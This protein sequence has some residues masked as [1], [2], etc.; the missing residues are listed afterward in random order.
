MNEWM[1]LYLSQ[2]LSQFQVLCAIALKI[3]FQMSIKG[4]IFNCR[5]SS[6]QLQTS[7]SHNLNL[8]ENLWFLK[9]KQ[10]VKAFS[11]FFNII[12]HHRHNY[13]LTLKRT[14]LGL[15]W[16]RMTASPLT[17]TEVVLD[18][19]VNGVG[20][21]V[22]EIHCHPDSPSG[23]ESGRGGRWC[24]GGWR[25]WGRRSNLCVCSLEKERER[26]KQMRNFCTHLSW[27]KS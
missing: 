16:K 26:M 23:Q 21:L 25:K 6:L 4:N 13:N 19:P 14:L 24:C 11:L 17:W 10:K 20:A 12:T 9:K 3:H 1:S 7:F 8:K 18:G 2:S 22:E 15:M 27:Y 5:T